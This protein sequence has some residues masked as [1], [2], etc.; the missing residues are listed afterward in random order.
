MIVAV[1]LTGLDTSRDR[2]D[3]RG[4]QPAGAQVLCP[5]QSQ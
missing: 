1:T 2:L 4:S 3:D 5:L